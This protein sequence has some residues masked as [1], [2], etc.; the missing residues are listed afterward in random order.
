MTIFFLT[1]SILFTVL[2]LILAFENMG[3]SVNGFL[4]IFFPVDS[5]F[6][7][8]VALCGIGIFA[9]VFYTALV[10]SVLHKRGEDE[11]ELGAE[12]LE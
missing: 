11:E 6:F 5:P 10:T 9:G 3:V 8:V 7:M 4:L 12:S 1:G 2:M